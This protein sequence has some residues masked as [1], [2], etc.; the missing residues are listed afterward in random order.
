MALTKMIMMVE[1][2]L[3]IM[4]SELH[5]EREQRG[6]LGSQFEVQPRSS[7][8]PDTQVAPRTL[9]TRLLPPAS[10]CGTTHPSGT[11]RFTDA[12]VSV[13]SAA[14]PQQRYAVC[15]V[16]PLQPIASI[17]LT[18]Q[19]CVMRIVSGDGRGHLN[20]ASSVLSMLSA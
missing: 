4:F 16:A 9:P 3:M 14:P 2:F 13:C 1:L 10:Y 6:Q 19:R 17:Q 5:S 11:K 7:A 8:F 12:I 18:L 20:F 15:S